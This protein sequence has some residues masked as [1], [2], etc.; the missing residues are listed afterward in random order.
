M[1]IPLLLQLRPFRPAPQG[2]F[3]LRSLWSLAAITQAPPL[4]P[5]VLATTFF[6]LEFQVLSCFS[7]FFISLVQL[8][9][10][11][12]PRLKETTEL[13]PWSSLSLLVSLLSC[14]EISPKLTASVIYTQLTVLPTSLQ[15]FCLAKLPLLPTPAATLHLWPF[16]TQNTQEA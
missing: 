6:A 1:T 12:L 8:H 16:S 9:F 7:G 13:C 3:S 10:L 2:V 14:S 11:L 4:T 5:A 15:K